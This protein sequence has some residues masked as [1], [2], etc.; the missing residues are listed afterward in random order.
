MERVTPRH[1]VQQDPAQG[2]GLTV[3]TQALSNLDTIFFVGEAG[4]YE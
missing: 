3:S 2:F 4:P 1:L